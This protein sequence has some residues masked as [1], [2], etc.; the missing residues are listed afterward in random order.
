LVLGDLPQ[1]L[2]VSFKVEAQTVEQALHPKREGAAV[3]LRVVGR[4]TYRAAYIAAS[5]QVRDVASGPYRAPVG[6]A[7]GTVGDSDNTRAASAP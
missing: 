7:I 4:P 1:K 6:H 3:C 2:S 5:G